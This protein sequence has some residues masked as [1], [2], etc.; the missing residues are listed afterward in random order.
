LPETDLPLLINAAQDAAKI[1]L[2]YWKTDQRVDTKDG[3]S[4]VSEGD[5][6]VDTYLKDTLLKA[7]PDY[8]WLSEET[9]DDKSRLSHDTVFIVDPIDGTRAYVAGENTW[10]ISIGVVHKGQPA[11]GVVYLPAR[12]KLYSAA[13][14][15]G[16]FLNG[17]AVRPASRTDPVGAT[18]LAPKPSLNPEWWAG[19]LPAMKR[20]YRPSLAYRFCLVAEGRF[21]VMLTL[22]DAWEWD[23][24]AGT[25]IATEAGAAV[26]DRN[27]ETLTMNSNTA[28]SKGI[29]TANPGLQQTLIGLY[30]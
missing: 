19:E 11:A 21:D 28:K 4:P 3:G 6:A 5:F 18:V 24:A 9:E 8:G 17:S 29:F 25:L 1:A 14:G 15:K 2:S 26:T 16:A 13:I 27:G 22:R 23:I 10:A 7:R 30:N 20:H 12:D